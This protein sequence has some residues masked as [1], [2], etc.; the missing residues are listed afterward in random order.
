MTTTETNTVRAPHGGR[1]RAHVVV[2]GGGY[3]GHLAAQALAVRTDARITLVN[4]GDR[5]TQRIRLHEAA[6]GQEPAAPRYVDLLAGTGV[7]FVD[8][9]AVGLDP[10]A[11]RVR[12]RDGDPLDYDLLVLALGSRP[13]P[14]ALPGPV[15]EVS[16]AEG[17]ARLRERLAADDVGRVAVVGGGLTGLELAT[18]LG[19][20]GRPTTLVTDGALGA[21]LSAR[22]ARHVREVCDRLGI[23]VVEHA[24]AVAAHDDGLTLAD[25]RTVAADIVVG[26]TGFTVPSLAREAGLA[27]DEHGRVLVDAALRSRSHPEILAVGDAAAAT[28]PD[29]QVLR[30]ACATALPA[31]QQAARTVA[32]LLAGTAPRPLRFRFA[33][34]CI[35]LGR[36][37]GLVQFVQPD[38]SPREL[39]VTGRLAAAVKEAIVVNAL[40]VQRHP[41]IPT[42]A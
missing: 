26:T 20:T 34:R 15:F 9:R 8:D 3:G 6:V 19:E 29:G 16:S 10:A 23:E 5:F 30:M 17:A 36:R 18:E 32:A 21:D 7:A 4:D 14:D 12:L 33:I 27:V 42:G 24:R 38:D 2:L 40:R 22:G 39:V 31:A 1:D 11:R 28:R 37:D 35:S 41:R 13:D 25:G